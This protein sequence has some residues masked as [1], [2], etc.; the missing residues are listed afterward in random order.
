[1]KTLCRWTAA[2]VGLAVAGYASLATFIWVRYG[3]APPPAYDERDALMDRFMPQYEVVER[4]RV[5]V[6][7]P[8]EI[9]L[10]AAKEADIEQSAIVRAI[11]RTRELV[12]GARRDSQRR[13]AGLLAQTTSLGW[14]V[15][16]EV[17]GR[18]VVVG[19]VTQPWLGE[20]VFRGVPPE[21]FAAFSEPGYVKIVWTLRADPAGPTSSVFRTETRVVATDRVARSKFRWYWARFS[22]GIAIIRYALLRPVKREAERRARVSR[23]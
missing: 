17:P 6:N 21:E 4:H 11:F 18:E 12:L 8:A 9:V 23:G 7:A 14:R 1:M 2:G 5:H 13:P 22:P 20:V 15:L 16:A 19:A 10:A 3:S